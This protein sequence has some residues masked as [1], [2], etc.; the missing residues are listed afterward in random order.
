MSLK[1]K[2][3]YLKV[4]RVQDIYKRE[5]IHE[6]INDKWIYDEYICEEFFISYTTFREYLELNV[7]RLLNS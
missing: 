6:G 2:N 1:K 5:K 4:Q 3:F 7:K